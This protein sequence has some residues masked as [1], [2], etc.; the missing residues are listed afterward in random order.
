MLTKFYFYFYLPL[1]KRN[2]QNIQPSPTW[3][4]SLTM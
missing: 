4:S 3:A 2:T 1:R